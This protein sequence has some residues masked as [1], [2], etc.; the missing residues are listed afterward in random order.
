MQIYEC[1]YEKYRKKLCFSKSGT[2]LIV[3]DNVLCTTEPKCIFVLC[4]SFYVV[5][6]FIIL[7]VLR[8]TIVPKLLKK[9]NFFYSNYFISINE[10]LT[11]FT[12]YELF[13]F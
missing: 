6:A 4:V 1:E 5:I 13:Q 7:I 8:I 9:N 3:L 10:S 12:S 2:L 11:F